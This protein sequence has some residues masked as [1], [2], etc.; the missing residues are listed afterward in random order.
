MAFR[1]LWRGHE[2][3]TWRNIRSHRYQ[4]DQY[5]TNMEGVA[6]VVSS[7]TGMQAKSANPG[8]GKIVNPGVS[9]FVIL[10]SPEVDP[11]G[12]V[13]SVQGALQGQA[14]VKLLQEPPI[15]S[16]LEVMQNILCT[17]MKDHSNTYIKRRMTE[18]KPEVNDP[19]VQ[20]AGCAVR[21][22]SLTDDADLVAFASQAT[23]SLGLGGI[24]VDNFVG[25]T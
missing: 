25:S 15:L 10:D 4:C 14:E 24:Y 9:Y 23:E 12:I 17:V 16:T 7:I 19:C 1:I 22:V 2:E 8:I 18:S 3:V 11:R 5:I 6:M 20:G 21:L 13:R